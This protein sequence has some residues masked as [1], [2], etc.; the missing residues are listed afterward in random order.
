ML[1][2]RDMWSFD[3]WNDKETHHPPKP[4]HITFSHS[5]PVQIWTDRAKSC[6]VLLLK[7]SK[8][9]RVVIPARRAKR[10]KSKQIMFSG[11]LSFHTRKTGLFVW[12]TID[13][14]SQA[15]TSVQLHRFNVYVHSNISEPGVCRSYE[16]VLCFMHKLLSKVIIVVLF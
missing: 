9:G 13:Q 4:Q 14:S 16:R 11:L 10:G 7:V 1:R 2:G 6:L 15:K 8:Q 12:S 3:S 5:R